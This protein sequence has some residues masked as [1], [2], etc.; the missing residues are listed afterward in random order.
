MPIYSH[1]CPDS[2]ITES[3][4]S[5]SSYPQTVDCGDCGATARLVI[6]SAPSFTVDR[7]SEQGFDHAAGQHFKNRA[8]K[9]AWM[10]TAGLDGGPIEE[11]DT[12]TSRKSAEQLQNKREERM[13]AD[14]SSVHRIK[15]VI[16]YERKVQRGELKP[17]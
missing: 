8:D 3:F 13:S 10:K 6:L 16:D 1:K 7:I 5:M 15:R 17:V 2:H 9:K 14:P 11:V 4:H 12:S